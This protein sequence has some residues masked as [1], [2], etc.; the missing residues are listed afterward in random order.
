MEI[1]KK[2]QLLGYDTES[3]RDSVRYTTVILVRM[4]SLGILR[5]KKLYSFELSESDVVKTFLLTQGIVQSSGWLPGMVFLVNYF[6]L[7]VVVFFTP[8]QP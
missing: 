3:H 6:A 1:G 5:R 8:F 2:K 7:R 4:L